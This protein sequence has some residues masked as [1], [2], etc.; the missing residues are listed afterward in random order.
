MGDNGARMAAWKAARP[1]RREQAIALAAAA[2]DGLFWLLIVLTGIIWLSPLSALAAARDTIAARRKRRA[3]IANAS[4]QV[5]ARQ[6]RRNAALAEHGF[7]RRRAKR[8]DL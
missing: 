4:S 3:R 2:S 7:A 1:M 6:A 5:W 8:P